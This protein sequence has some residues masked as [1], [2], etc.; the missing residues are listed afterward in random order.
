MRYLSMTP[1]KGMLFASLAVLLLADAASAQGRGRG[2]GGWSQGYYQSYYP[3]TDAYQSQQTGQDG[4]YR[5]YYPP[6]T[7][8]PAT[9]ELVVPADA[10]VW[11]NGQATTLT[12]TVR[13]FVT[14][15]LNAD[16][17]YSY[18]LKIRWNKDGQPTE[19][20]RTIS[21]VAGGLRQL[22]LLRPTRETRENNKEMRDR[23]A[24]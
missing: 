18:E 21:V 1:T 19:E 13:R 11:F 20:T 24:P 6:A 9:I 3:P 4:T 2:R 15:P 5:S 16:A 14:P 22:N 17:D 10:Q 23:E 8:L 12:G 7:S